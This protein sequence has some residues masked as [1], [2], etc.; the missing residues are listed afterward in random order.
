MKH[1]LIT[2]T[3][4]FYTHY[5]LTN[6]FL[7]QRIQCHLW[8]RVKFLTKSTKQLWKIKGY[9]KGS[10]KFS[11]SSIENKQFTMVTAKHLPWRTS[12]KKYSI[13]VD[14]I[15][16]SLLTGFK[17]FSILLLPWEWSWDDN[18]CSLSPLNLPPSLWFPW[19]KCDKMPYKR[20]LERRENAGSPVNNIDNK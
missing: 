6:T 13:W 17:P 11:I 20:G 16:T 15:W 4:T 7:H 2:V 18:D 8:L 5:K 1:K 3:N 14:S 9:L 19:R 10:M 12:F